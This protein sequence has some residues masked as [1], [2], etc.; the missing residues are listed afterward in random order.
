MDFLRKNMFKVTYYL[1]TLSL[2]LL[3]IFYFT[4]YNNISKLTY[5]KKYYIVKKNDS[6]FLKKAEMLDNPILNLE[7]IKSFVKEKTIVLFNYEIAFAND[8]LNSE[9][10]SFTKFSFKNF[11][12]LFNYRVEQESKSGV[13]IKESTITDGPYYLGNYNYLNKNAWKF[14]LQIKETRYG[15]S[16]NIN[17][18]NKTVIMI[19]VDDDFNKNGKGLAI[20]SIEII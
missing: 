18:S 20:D 8:K 11:N 3:P 19:V 7:S 10:S 2:F 1:I 6:S 12:E 9:E 17:F 16:G 5:E 4:F 13:V 14:Y 15:L